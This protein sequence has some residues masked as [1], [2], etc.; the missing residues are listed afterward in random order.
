[1]RRGRVLWGRGERRLGRRGREGRKVLGG[2]D[3]EVNEVSQHASKDRGEMLALSSTRQRRR[4][5]RGR[6]KAKVCPISTILLCLSL[7]GEGSSPFASTSP[8]ISLDSRGGAQNQTH[9]LLQM[10]PWKTK[11]RS[12]RSQTKPCWEEG[13]L[14]WMEGRE[15][16]GCG[17]ELRQAERT[18]RGR[19]GRPASE[20]GSERLRVGQLRSRMGTKN[21][22]IFVAA[23][24]TIDLTRRVE[25]AAPCLILRSLEEDERTAA[26]AA[27]CLLH[28]NMFR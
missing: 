13:R 7:L 25:Y 2:E 14:V 27:A 15:G 16:T 17:H 19:R 5:R 1:M 26:T 18:S 10:C 3:E 6:G 23:E 4:A 11:G 21:I 8:S 9:G 12:C 20:N 24:I 22:L 28:S